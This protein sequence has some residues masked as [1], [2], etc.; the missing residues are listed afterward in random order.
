MKF[1]VNFYKDK[2]GNKPVGMF[3]RTLDVKMKAKVTASIQLLEEYGDR[4]REPLSKHLGDGIFEIR[5]SEGNNIVRILYFFD[6]NRIIIAT[7]GFVKKT[8]KTPP[9]E[10][11]LAKERR[12]DYYRRRD[13]GTYE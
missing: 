2:D 13:A 5:V 8:R 9:S 4:A 3:I 7:N 1:Y 11:A 12:A 10:I 6:N